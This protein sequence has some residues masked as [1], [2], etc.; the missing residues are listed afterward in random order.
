MSRNQRPR[1][2]R[3]LEESHGLESSA[4]A[5]NETPAQKKTVER[6]MHEYKHGELK[7]ARGA[8]KVK[9]PK[10]AIAI[11]CTRPAP[12]NSRARKRARPICGGPGQ[13]NA[14]AKLIATRPKDAGRRAVPPA[15]AARM[16]KRA[17]SSTPRPGAATSRTARR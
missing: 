17:P 16:A 10:Q 15:R 1:P 8:R 13:R 12:R 9:N 7:T 14:P 2:I 4:M 5:T 3:G 6:V 11:A